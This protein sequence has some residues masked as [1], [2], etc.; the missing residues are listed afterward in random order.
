VQRLRLIPVRS[1][2]SFVSSGLC[3]RSSV[4]LAPCALG[5][6]RS[7]LAQNRAMITRVPIV[8]VVLVP[9]VLVPVVY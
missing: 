3:A 4:R 5:R 1:A 8:P 7:R 2:S 6:R 9:V